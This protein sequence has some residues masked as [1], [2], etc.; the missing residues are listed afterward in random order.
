MA[1]EAADGRST[2]WEAHRRER[3][4]AIITGAMSAIEEYGPEPLTG[5]IAAKAGVARTHVYRHFDDRPALDLAVCRYVAAQIGRRIRSGLATPGSAR[6]IIGG[7]IG[8]HLGWVESHPNLYKF[9]AQHAYLVSETG[10]PGSDDAKAV[11]AA[12]LTGVLQAYLKAFGVDPAPAQR[13]VIGVVGMVDATAAWWL[14]HRELTRAELTS[15]L[16]DQVWLIIDHTAREL[17]L[18]IDPDAELPAIERAPAA[19]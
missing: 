9:L 2:R 15:A 6:Q 10:S 13:V 12:E 18:I 16:T 14:D 1:D 17:G 19:H 5:Q 3:R 8:E 11:F 7:A 4:K